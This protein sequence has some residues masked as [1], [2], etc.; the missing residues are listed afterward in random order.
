M[1]DERMQTCSTS[2]VDDRRWFVDQG[3]Y[4]I[5][6]SEAAGLE[7]SHLEQVRFSSRMRVF[8]WEATTSDV[9]G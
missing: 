5:G 7:D 6:V 2:V 1:K 3:G 4:E 9:T 8:S